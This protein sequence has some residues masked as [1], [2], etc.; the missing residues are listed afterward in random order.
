MTNETPV[1]KY[2][3]IDETRYW[4]EAFVAGLGPGA[5]LIATYVYDETE[6]T[7][8]CEMTPSY[9]LEY[10]GT[11]VESGRELTEEE[12]EKVHEFIMQGDAENGEAGH[13]RHC[14]DVRRLKPQDLPGKVSCDTMDEVRE[15]WNGNHW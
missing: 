5:K 12:W 1:F 9:W 10:L 2:V 4:N 3:R 14:S 13:Y 7:Y 8:C 6:R 11:H 15:Y